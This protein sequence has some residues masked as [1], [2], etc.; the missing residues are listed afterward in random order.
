MKILHND[1]A[2]KKHADKY[3]NLALEIAKKATCARA[4]CGSVIVKDG[5]VIGVG[6][7][8]PPGNL[9][10]Q[11]RCNNSKDHYH[12]KVTD[13]TCCVHAEQRAIMDALARHPDKIK[14]STLYFMRVG[15][16][17]G[18]SFCAMPYCTICSKMTLDSGVSE[19]ALLYEDG[20]HVY[21][22]EEYNDVSFDYKE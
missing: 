17:G 4:Q 14:G 11:C 16:D 19:F 1:S 9:D 18:K 6:Y 10:S 3:M 2:E 7:N 13:K 5:V 20:I 22:S 21:D 8:S 15:E 12:K